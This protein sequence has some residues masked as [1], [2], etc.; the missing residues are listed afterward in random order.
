VPWEVATGWRRLRGLAFAPP[1][2]PLEIPRC[3]SVHT[4]GM[5]YPLDLIWLGA[6]GAVVR[7]DRAVPPRRLRVC[8]RARSVVEAPAVPARRGAAAAPSET[9]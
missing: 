2:G 3:R 1:A 9:A 7:V 4:F 8:R 6:D 5:R